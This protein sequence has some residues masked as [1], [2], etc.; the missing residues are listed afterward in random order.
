VFNISFTSKDL[1]RALWA[2]AFG[3]L[4]YIV[5]AQPQAE[6]GQWKAVGIGAVAAGLSAVKNLIFADGSTIKG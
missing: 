5:I 2:F 1:V 6:S 3:A 4:G